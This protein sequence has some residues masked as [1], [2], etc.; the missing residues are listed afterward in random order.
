MKSLLCLSLLAILLGG[1]MTPA[2]RAQQG[3][4]LT[5]TVTEAETGQTLPGASVLLVGTTQGT[6]TDADGRY[7]LTG[8]APGTYTVQVSF[9]GFQTALIPIT[10]A[11]GET[12]QLDVALEAAVSELGNITVETASRRAEKLVNAP[13]SISVL[14]A[15]EIASDAATSTV[16][17]LRNTT[18]VDMAQTGIDRRE[19]VLRGFNNAFSGATYALVDYRQAAAP[20]LAVNLWSIMPNAPIDVDRVEIVRGPGSALYGAGVDAGVVHFIT[21]DPFTNPGTTIALTGGERSTFGGQ[22]RH[23][24]SAGNVGYKIVGSYLQAHEW[25]LDP[26]DPV[27]AAQ[28]DDDLIARN[29]DYQKYQ[30]NAELQYRFNP[31][32]RLILNGGTSGLTTPTLSGIGTLQADGYGYSFGQIRLQAGGL[33]AQVYANF[34]DA[35][36]SFVYGQDRNRDGQPDPVVDKGQLYNAQVQYS[37][38]LLGGRQQFVFGADYEAIIPRTEGTINGRNEDDDTITE[39]GV[40]AQSS[41]ELTDQLDLTLALRGDYNN[42][43]EDFQISPRVALVFEPVLNHTLRATFNRAFSSPGSNSNFLDIIARSPDAQL[44]FPI[45]ARGSANG[46]TF[47][48][49]AEWGQVFGSDLV[50]SSLSGC[51]PTPTPAC[52]AEVP[53]GLTLDPIYASLYDQVSVLPIEFNPADDVTSLTE[54]LVGSGLVP[55]PTTSEEV[56]QLVAGVRAIVDLLSPSNTTVAGVSQGRLAKL[57]TSTGTFEPVSDAVDVQPLKQTTS[58]TFEVGYKGIINNRV[59][60]SVDGYYVRKENFVGP[61]LME[62]PVVLVPELAADFRAA[63]EAGIQGNVALAAALGQFGVSPAQ[64]AGL[65]AG[66]AADA[67]PGATTPVAIVQPRENNAGP[68][69]VP[70]LMLAYRNFGQVDYYGI[71]VAAEVMAT[72]E[73]SV[74]GNLSWVSD[75]FFDAEELDEENEDLAL[76]LNA[77]SLKV[78]GGVGYAKPGGFSAS[79]A[80]RYVEGFPVRSGPYVGMVDSYFLLDLG[81]GYDFTR[82]VPGLRLDVTIQNVLD[83]MHREFVGAPKIGRMGMARLSYSF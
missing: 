57:N 21:K 20:A 41:T 80:G 76:A 61:L 75:D 9:T 43:V 26:N 29:Y 24:G 22:F 51:F 14:S 7:R 48:R 1:M 8:I 16:A 39:T 52:G 56:A 68:G 31:T 10:L 70:E 34:N 63:L 3:A 12:R 2:A 77:P 59:F 60:L 11:A 64:L 4:T 46:F 62:T 72:D 42:I 5:G 19:V 69:N 38:P 53:V 71:D 15:R 83:N 28:L 81:L 82:S 33:F 73:I 67:L 54:I 17:A 40:Y 49:R 18:G 30:V 44:P 58:S 35:G 66:F 45:R 13:A 78:K 23:A 25:E 74:F 47:Q 36:E 37:L 55:A 79:L 65:L 50:A 6:A 27:D 32:T